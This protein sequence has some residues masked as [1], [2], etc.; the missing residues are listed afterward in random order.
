M[1]IKFCGVFSQLNSRYYTPKQSREFIK[2]YPEDTVFKAT[3]HNMNFYK[4]ENDMLVHVYDFHEVK[5]IVEIFERTQYAVE[6]LYENRLGVWEWVLWMKVDS[7]EDGHRTKRNG[8]RNKSNSRGGF[9]DL[10][11]VEILEKGKV[12][13]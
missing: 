13:G 6:G 1:G 4:L 9:K 7:E 3:R 8:M 11:V 5:E 10:R 2:T 12:L